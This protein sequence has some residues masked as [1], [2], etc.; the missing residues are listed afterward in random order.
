MR[1]PR[2][3]RVRERR[4]LVGSRFVREAV[5]HVGA[6]L[7]AGATS[8]ARAISKAGSRR[9]SWILRSILGWGCANLTGENKPLSCGL[10]A[11]FSYRY[12]HP[13]SVQGLRTRQCMHC[14]APVC[15]LGDSG[16]KEQ[17]FAIRSS[18]RGLQR[19]FGLRGRAQ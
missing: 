14:L 8:E 1:D 7:G 18:Q 3:D 13:G 5:L 15:G 6:I 19:N 12:P 9:R 16:A 4:H 2:L 10:L 17:F 11:C